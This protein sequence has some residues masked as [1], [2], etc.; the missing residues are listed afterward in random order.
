LTFEEALGVVY[1]RGAL[2]KKYQKLSTT[3]GAMLAVDLGQQEAN[4]CLKRLRAGNVVVA[5]VNSPSS[6]TLSGSLEAIEEVE[7][8]LSSEAVFARKLRVDS[9]YHSHYMLPMAYEYLERLREVIKTPKQP[10]GAIIYSSPVT[11]QVLSKQEYL[12][13]ENWVR[14]LTQPV[15]FSQSLEQ[16]CLPGGARDQSTRTDPVDFLLEI[17]PHGALAGPIRQ[18]L[19]VPALKDCNISYA[20]CLTR[21]EDAVKTM[22]T[23]ACS[24]ICRGC[25]VNISAVNFPN[26][27][28]GLRVI[29]D[30]PSYP[31]N[32]STKYWKEPRLNVAYRQRKHAPHELLGSLV[33]GTNPRAPTWR[34]FLRAIDL[35]WLRDH[36]LQ[37]DMVF[38]AAASV[39]MAIEAI[40]QI[41]DPSGQSI[42]G[43]RLRD[44]DIMNALIIPDTIEGIEVQ[45][46]FKECNRRE[47]DEQGW[48]EFHLY[49]IT[50]SGESWT[51][52][53][54]GYVSVKSVSATAESWSQ[55][56]VDR[57]EKD[58]SITTLP[59]KQDMKPD[60][61]FA[62]LREVGIYHGPLFRNLLD[63]KTHD[64]YSM[65]T[66][67]VRDVNVEMKHRPDHEH[68]LHP[69]TLDSIFL[70]AY[71]TLDGSMYEN[72]MMLPRSIS[73]MYVSEAIVRKGG[74]QFKAFSEK[75]RQ[76]MQGFHSSIT[77]T[78]AENQDCSP[79]LEVKDLFCQSVRQ[80]SSSEKAFEKRK[81]CFK[82]VWHQDW[83]LMSS[84]EMRELLALPPD[85][86]E[87][88]I[89]EKLVQA[90]F[91][92]I[93]DAIAELTE[94]D[95]TNLDWHQIILLD[96]MRTQDHL[97]TSGQLARGSAS[98][99]KANEGLK[100][101]LF[102]EVS[103][104]SVNGQLLCRIGKTLADILKKKT[105][106]LEVMMEGKLLFKFYEQAL[107]CNRSYIQV[108]KLVELYAQKTPQGKILEIGGGTGGCTTSVLQA[109]TKDAASN[110]FNF[111]HYD[112][113]D[114]SP[115]FF[116]QAAQ[117]FRI[118]SHLMSFKKLDIEQDPVEQSFEAGSY[119]LVIAYQ[120]LHATKNMVNTMSNVRKMLKPGGKLILVET[121]RDTID[122]QLIFGVLPGWWLGVEEERRTS[123]NLSVDLWKT[124]VSKTGFSGI[125][126]EVGDCEDRDNYSFSTMLT[127]AIPSERHY[128]DQISIISPKG[129]S[130]TW[131]K[132]LR[133]SI[134]HTTGVATIVEDLETI[135]AD[136]KYCIIIHEMLQP[137]L[138]QLSADVFNRLRSTLTTAKGALWVTS[139]GL[140]T[141]TKPEYGLLAGLLRTLR[142]ENA[143]RRLVSVDLEPTAD[144]WN[145]EACNSIVKVF[146]SAFE[147]STAP[148][149][150]D[151]EYAVK[152]SKIHMSRIYED[153]DEN[154]ATAALAES[155]DEL[156][157][158]VGSDIPLRMEIE[159]TGLLDSLRFRE[160]KSASEPLPDDHVEIEPK[161]FGLNFRDVLVALGQLDET[162]MGY[163][164]SGIVTRLGSETAE[165][166]LKVGDR[167][168]AILR[169]HWATR[170]RIQ[171][172]CVGR[173]P[174][175]M[176][177]E[178]AAS[179]PTV[180]ITAYHS[181]YDLANLSE[182]ET[183]LIHAATGGVGQAAIMLAQH[184]GAE[185][186]VTVSTEAKRDFIIENYGIPATHIFSSRDT[187]FATGVMAATNDKG[188]DV[189]LNSLAGPLLKATWNCLATFGR[190][191]EI[192]KR[193]M[194]QGKTLEMATFR[195]ATTFVAVDLFLVSKF[196][197]RAIARAMK[198]I[199]HLFSEKSIKAVTPI[200]Q[201]SISA[202]SK[203]FR[204]MQAGKHLGK[205]V[206]VPKPDDFVKACV[207]NSFLKVASADNTHR[208]PPQSSMSSSPLSILTSSWADLEVSDDLWH[209]TWLGYNARTLSCF[210]APPNHRPAFMY[211][212]RNWQTSVAS[213]SSAT[214]T[215][216]TNPALPES[217]KNVRRQCLQSVVW[218]RPQVLSM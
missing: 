120:V 56:L 38:P 168:C 145:D 32:H 6:V 15:L 121:T 104:S 144:P 50:P 125:E 25:P 150:I 61:I 141:A 69:T 152:D 205:I 103:S 19:K 45:L 90:T 29:S 58:R 67:K 200:T 101:L 142:M 40:R 203:A 59:F 185:V 129:V 107:H 18:N 183:V 96:W 177:F 148:D 76:D 99:A 132:N 39:S 147:L 123:P 111:A 112:F 210:H 22:Q 162:V 70:A 34:N 204:L 130:H 106:P 170:I 53:S 178:E 31:W 9:A 135:Q 65:T 199:L 119:D 93:H 87:V 55:T 118:W 137:M 80:A 128:P 51:L 84:E 192:G 49:S 190:F 12:D 88:S 176:T 21:G 171:W 166:G 113:T 158:F 24:L 202:V 143:G 60:S 186:F 78:D 117:K 109:L 91:H 140:I 157:P 98:W 33:V 100:E 74:H 193:D 68:V 2:A 196:R 102:D 159:T 136:G 153:S 151:S 97:G 43:Y 160:D 42:S 10:R 7:R 75:L 211:L 83:N 179:I 35:P 62:G 54:K 156:R 207:R 217:L 48:Y 79:V 5:C 41:T 163:E 138:H 115:G 94:D 167:V 17:G 23:V 194:E 198:K 92:F 20:S 95:I 46:S 213:P 165:S 82:I 164:C 172:T 13:A 218:F 4:A 1:F 182:G 131:L 14:N 126:V 81:T 212:Y 26:G 64:Q 57:Y 124:I 11:G 181:L 127:T 189:V 3:K 71:T 175:G 155:E 105:A 133:D 86:Q 208:S 214:V 201:Y 209:A 72:A 134:T 173:I 169:G 187:S 36:L 108:K 73:Q 149:E 206:V 30:L 122:R 28:K 174:D 139:A 184:R 154:N 216:R 8:T 114:I 146:A 77:V 89:N 180:F 52:H 63:I 116:E 47:L 161:A 37:P 16:M 188:V 191:I 110:D 66:F 85:P 44:V 195:R 27:T 197:G 215:S